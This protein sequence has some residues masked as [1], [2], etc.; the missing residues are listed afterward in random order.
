M[1][2]YTTIDCVIKGESECVIED[3]IER[4]LEQVHN[5]KQIKFLEEK[6]D[7]GFNWTISN[8]GCDFLSITWD[9]DTYKNGDISS[10]MR[11]LFYMS[12]KYNLHLTGSASFTA[13][14]GDK[15][16]G[17]AYITLNNV[18]IITFQ[19]EIYDDKHDPLTEQNVHNICQQIQIITLSEIQKDIDIDNNNYY[20]NEKKIFNEMNEY[21][22]NITQIIDITEIIDIANLS[23]I[24]HKYKLNGI[25]LNDNDIGNLVE[26]DS[27]KNKSDYLI[28]N[29]DSIKNDINILLIK[30]KQIYKCG[31]KSSYFEL[32][33]NKEYISLSELK[34]HIE[35]KESNYNKNF[36]NMEFV[37]NKNGE[38]IFYNNTNNLEENEIILEEIND[39]VNRV[40]IA[41]IFKNCTEEEDL[42]R[43]FYRIAIEYMSYYIILNN[44]DIK[45]VFDSVLN[46]I[47]FN[48]THI[49]IIIDNLLKRK[50]I[51]QFG[52]KSSYFELVK[53]KKFISLSELKLQIEAKK[54]NYTKVFKDME[55][56]VNNKGEYIFK[57]DNEKI[58]IK[59]KNK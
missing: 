54:S 27:V 53:D 3:D 37:V 21:I 9:N 2:L 1:G 29:M 4:V 55:F 43:I 34:L 16:F 14:T 30:N 49:N 15:W 57:E 7:M 45:H 58:K 17:I 46:N 13:V 12:I 36:R 31:D 32:V 40:E 23:V 41:D 11:V 39:Y 5:K 47:H 24:I 18:S 59:L 25:I 19:N 42:S 22:N 8:E 56:L 52:D 35:A 10:I 28:N 38:Y 20:L 44:N 33:K 51:Y 26:N 6:Y 48:E 50:L